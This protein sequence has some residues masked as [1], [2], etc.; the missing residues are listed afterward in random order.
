ML[1]QQILNGLV[2]GAVYALFALG[3]NLTFGVHKIMNLA[4]GA[5]FMIG[6]FAGLVT[7]WQGGPL[8]LAFVAGALASGVVSV[9]LDLIAFH[10]LRKHEEEEFAAII[11]SLGASMIIG[12]IVLRLTDAK[13]LRFPFGLVPTQP[14]V[15]FGLR[16]SVLQL[17]ICG[18]VAGLVALLYGYLYWTD[19]GRQVRAVAGNERAATLIGIEPIA[20]FSQTFFIS[21]ALAGIAGVITGLTFNSISYLMGDPYLLKAFVVLVLGGLGNIAGAVVASL[22]IGV[23]Q[24]LTNAYL[25]TG[26]SDIVIYSILFLMLVIRPNGLFGQAVPLSGTARK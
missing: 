18:L 17:I 10:H 26:L 11:A 24:S 2:G 3:F 20:V 14:Y 22:I 9:A 6:A 8:W 13:I 21:G 25:E 1:S 4:H 16:V 23:I 19:R 5:I 15:F 12:N 7:V